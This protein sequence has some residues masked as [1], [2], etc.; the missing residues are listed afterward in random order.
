MCELNIY[1]AANGKTEKHKHCQKK[2][3]QNKC[4]EEERSRSMGL[5]R[6]FPEALLV[7]TDAVSPPRNDKPVRCDEQ[8][9]APLNEHSA[10]SI[11]L[12]WLQLLSFVSDG[13]FCT[14]FEVTVTCTVKA[15]ERATSNSPMKIAEFNFLLCLGLILYDIICGSFFPHNTV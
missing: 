1:P 3:S 12:L 5:F 11:H 4:N 6:A 9:G 14:P 10:F 13:Y 7:L 15:D 2:K 8:H